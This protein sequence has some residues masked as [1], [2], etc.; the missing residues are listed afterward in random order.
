MVTRRNTPRKTLAS[1]SAGALL[2]AAGACVQNQRVST[3][4]NANETVVSSTPPFETK[5]PERYSVTRTITTVSA[6]GE[7]RVMKTSVVRD[8]ELRRLE[9]ELA[10]QP[11]V[12]LTLREGRFLLLPEQK[13]FAEITSENPAA[14]PGHADES[15]SSPDRLL[16]TEP[17]STSY[18]RLGTE[19]IGGRL[20]Q[21]YRVVVNSSAGANVSESESVVWLDETLHMPIRSEAISRD[22]TRVTMELSNITLNVDPRVFQIPDGYEKI[23]SIE[24]AKRWK[25]VD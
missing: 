11:V 13:V 6:T 20:T 10:S 2:L 4:P 21:K 7:T 9:D 12:Y 5:E 23:T 1:F 17:I 14:P 18:Q 24:L 15:D 3:E 25:T 16:H 22:G 8:G 19:A